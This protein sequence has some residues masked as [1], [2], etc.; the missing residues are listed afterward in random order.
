MIVKMLPVGP[1]AANCVIVGCE[2]TGRAIV[3]D[4]GAE[5]DRILS[6]AR[7]LGLEIAAIVNTHGHAD[8]I[9]ANNQVKRATGAPVMIG[10]KDAEMLT[11]AAKNLSL[12]SGL[13]IRSDAADRLLREGDVV[14]VGDVALRVIET[15]G[16]TPGGISLVA[17]DKVF[18]GDSLFAGSVGRTDLPGGS[19][20]ALMSSV[21]NKLLAL[22]DEFEVYPGHGPATTIGKERISNP[23][24]G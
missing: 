10:E 7:S 14:E 3:I 11:S 20:E 19:F 4:P 1:L 13:A 17:D 12:L 9:G 23:F 22:G 16:H 24:V 18:T 2:R 15:P 5:G 21:N 8:H 6:T